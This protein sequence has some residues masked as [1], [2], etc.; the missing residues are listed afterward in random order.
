M[1]PL[2]ALVGRPNVG[3][4]TLFNRIVG[5]RL[6][7]VEDTPGGTRDRQYPEADHAGRPFRAV[8]TGGFPPRTPHQ[9]GAP[10]RVPAV[11]ALPETA[12][13]VRGA[14]TTA[15]PATPDRRS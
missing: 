2:V 4:S 5:R 15:K 3:K 1:L 11:A 6:A 13:P 14:V 7:I 10:G 12:V 8:D 9:Q